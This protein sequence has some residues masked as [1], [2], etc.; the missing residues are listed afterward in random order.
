MSMCLPEPRVYESTG[1][2]FV[3]FTQI[4]SL[5]TEPATGQKPN[6][7]LFNDRILLMPEP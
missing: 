5:R 1:S 7:S 6:K 2:W 3:S 4:P